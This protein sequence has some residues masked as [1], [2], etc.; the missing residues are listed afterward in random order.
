MR[1]RTLFLAALALAA[2]A[3]AGCA[4]ND[5]YGAHG[6]RPDGKYDDRAN[7]P[8]NQKALGYSDEAVA[9]NVRA[10]LHGNPEIRGANIQVQVNNGLVTLS[11]SVGSDE[12]RIRALRT[13]ER[14]GG[15]R[16]VRNMMGSN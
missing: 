8:T 9:Q 10:A 12:I 1:T 2:T 11:G 3:I 16:Q 4:T 6:P 5:P 15:V 14:V 7:V 13:A